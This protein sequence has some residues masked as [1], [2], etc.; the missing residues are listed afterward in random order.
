[1]E[2]TAEGGRER[3][4]QTK[5]PLRESVFTGV[6]ASPPNRNSFRAPSSLPVYPH[7][8]KRPL[9]EVESPPDV[10][11]LTFTHNH[12]EEQHVFRRAGLERVRQ[13]VDPCAI[14]YVN[15]SKR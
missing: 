15:R 8:H 5:K 11:S 3:D 6:L 12:F 4:G 14:C 10:I 2:A 7:T 13:M 9:R 1:M